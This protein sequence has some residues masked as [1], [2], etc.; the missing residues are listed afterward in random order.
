MKSLSLE[1]VFSSM[2]SKIYT[3]DD[4]SKGKCVVQNTGDF[5]LLKE[6]LDTAYPNDN[7]EKLLD[8]WSSRYF[9]GV[10]YWSHSD[11]IEA[12]GNKPVQSIHLFFP[13]KEVEVVPTTVKKESLSMEE[14]LTELKNKADEIGLNLQITFTK[15]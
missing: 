13:K 15:K 10:N 1:K 12:F 11:D 9:G 7:T 3:I 2:D 8:Y 5:R 6:L 4:L 14:L